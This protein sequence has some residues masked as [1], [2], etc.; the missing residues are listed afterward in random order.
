MEVDLYEIVMIFRFDYVPVLLERLKS[1]PPGFRIPRGHRCRRLDFY[2]GVRESQPYEDDAWYEGGHTLWGLVCACPNLEILMARVVPTWDGSVYSHLTHKS[3]WKIIA[4][5]CSKNLRR[6]EL[7]GLQIRMDRVEMML[8]YFSKLEACCI[9]HATCFDPDNN[10]YD[11][12]EP[13]EREITRGRCRPPLTVEDS[14]DYSTSSVAPPRLRHLNITRYNTNGNEEADEEGLNEA[15]RLFPTSPTHLVYA[16]DAIAMDGFC[17]HLR[18]LTLAIEYCYFASF[19]FI[20]PYPDLE[21]IELVTW[22]NACKPESFFEAILNAVSNKMLPSL[23]MIQITRYIKES[24]RFQAP[25]DSEA[26]GVAIK[27]VHR[28]QSWLSGREMRNC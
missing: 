22:T 15:F 7:H 5:Y 6:L 12:E 4:T 21:A 2:L 3:L 8:R 27:E 26:F 24:S 11:D 10:V 19:D 28:K 9:I 25:Q 20:E 14:W 17:P 18:S 13:K 23:R 1:T 16:G